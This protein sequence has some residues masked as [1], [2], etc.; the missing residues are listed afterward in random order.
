MALFDLLARGYFPKELPRPFVTMPFARVVTSAPALPGDF[1]K[2]ASK[3]NGPRS[4]KSGRYFHA[5]GG[6][7]RRR[8]DICNP[9]LYF[10][11]CREM[12]QNW[13]SIRPKVAGTALSATAP[14]FKTVGR[15][16]EGKHAQGDRA[17]LAQDARLGRKYILRTD[18]SRFYGSIY[19][20]SIPWALHTK[21]RAKA[22]RSLKLLG[23]K[24][25]Y[26][27]RGGQD[28]QTVG[29]P[30]GPDTSLVL[31][32]LIMQ[33]CDA[34]LISELPV[35][36]GYR[37]IDDY[38]LS[39]H[40]RTEAEDAFD[41]LEGC[42][43]DYELA[44]NPRKT[45]I[46][47]LHQPLEAPWV[48][49]LKLLRFRTSRTGQAADLSNFFNR[50]YALQAE[51]PGEAVL[52][53]AVASMRSVNIEPANWHLFQKLLLLC[54]IP[55]PASLPYVLEEVIVRKNAGAP[56]ILGQFEEIANELIQ[57]HSRLRHSSEVANAAWACLA[58]GLK[59]DQKTVDAI[60]R[61][62]DPVVALLALDCERNGLVAK[63]LDRALWASHMHAD[64]LY[65]E[66]WLLSYEANA[67]GWLPSIRGTD[68]VAADP[69]FGFLKANGVRFYDTVQ[70]APAPGAPLPVPTLPT[71]RPSSTSG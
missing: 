39:F 15:A 36:R 56:A 9:L 10:H 34:A 65:S 70:A 6:R 52:N 68:H 51:H 26:W 30:I 63:P 40:T 1:A 58:L 37:F 32:E 4:A 17:T 42:L 60:S 12:T 33:G 11:L 57:A 13:S 16:I 3:K 14:V 38:E 44:L 66:H 29:I 59:L 19:T 54:V 62:D 7:L 41:I 45:E 20:H 35:L 8:L 49:D 2:S 31:A 27:I 50:A 5:R 18:I 48:T 64:A 46:R 22:S 67:Q 53:Y 24:I 69:N 43:S 25:D 71:P 28:Q 21:K 47:Q 61:C 23:N 55:E